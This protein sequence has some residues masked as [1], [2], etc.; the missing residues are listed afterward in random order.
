[1]GKLPF[2]DPPLAALLREQLSW[3]I[4]GFCLEHRKTGGNPMNLP[5]Q[6]QANEEVISVIKRHPASLWGRLAWEDLF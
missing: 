1:M 6:L 2:A 5:V 3:R 4:R